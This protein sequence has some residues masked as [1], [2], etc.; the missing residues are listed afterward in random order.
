MEMVLII[1]MAIMLVYTFN[2]YSHVSDSHKIFEE[3][4]EKIKQNQAMIRSELA[5]LK[6]QLTKDK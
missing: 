1:L 2:Q 6:F 5:S 4:Q 3:N